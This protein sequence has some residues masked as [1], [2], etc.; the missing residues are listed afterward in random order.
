[1]ENSKLVDARGLSCPQPAL[2]TSRVLSALSGGMVEVLVDSATARDN[3]IRTAEK[4]GW[5]A[6]TE[7]LSD[8]SF[9]LTLMK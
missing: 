8:G 2:M 7:A 6:A 3:V 5:K 4:A 9:Q 1:M